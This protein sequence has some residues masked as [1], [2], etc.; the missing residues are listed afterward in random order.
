MKSEFEDLMFRAG[1]SVQE[2]ASTLGYSESHIYRWIRGEEIP[3]KGILRALQLEIQ[4]KQI[5]SDVGD[6]TF[7]DLFAGIGGLRAALTVAGGRC[8]FT[9]EWDR[10]AQQTYQSNYTDNRP[11]AGD[12]TEIPAEEIPQHDVLA[13]G[14]PCQPFSIAGVSKKNSLGRKHGFQDE[15]Q[16]T[17]FFDVLQIL[18][19]HR[20][21][22][23]ILENVK[24]LMGHDKGRTFRII[25]QKLSEELNYEF[26]FKV[27]DAAHFLPQHRERIIMVGFSRSTSFSFD[28]IKL[29]TPN[30]VLMK[31]ILHPENG[32][33]TEEPPYTS[34][35]E[36][37]VNEKYVLSD[38]LWSYLQEYAAKHKARGNGFGFGLVDGDSVSRT[39]SA[40][41]FK[42]GSEILVD[43]GKA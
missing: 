33:E 40:R 31:S 32:T 25:S 38:K 7:V 43:R 9:S 8:L 11:I 16:G 37:K 24:N 21:K 1:Y 20:P 6:F 27:I 22:A 19:H 35:V 2:A 34:G 3:R 10:F 41:Y 30:R 36:G 39:L 26:H 28:D 5:Q 29:P 4:T 23:F 17:L 42:D 14:F 13:A 18:R 12:I 15:T